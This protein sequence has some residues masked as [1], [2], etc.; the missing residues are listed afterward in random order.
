MS[1]RYPTLPFL[2]ADRWVG[3]I[4]D[5]SRSIAVRLEPR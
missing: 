4:A 3:L 5:I 1:A 2:T